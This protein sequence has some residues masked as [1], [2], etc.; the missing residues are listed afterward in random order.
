MNNMKQKPVVQNQNGSV[1]SKGKT[2][3]EAIANGLAALNLTAEQVDIDII[4]HGSR[5]ILGLGAEEAVV[6]LTPKETAPVAEPVPAADPVPP[7]EADTGFDAA[8]VGRAK[9]IL[10]ALLENMSLEGTV[11]SRLGTDLVDADDQPPLVLDIEGSDLGLLIGRRGETLQ[12][13]QFVTRQILNKEMG[14]W[15]PVVVD[16][17]SYLARRRKTLQQLADRM[18]E[19][20]VSSGRRVALEPM[21]AH[22]RRI[23]HMHLRNHDSVYTESTGEGERRKVVILPK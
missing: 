19:R 5:G 1:E 17:E 4:N 2:V 16:V 9:E 21:S 15:V 14:R 3:D 12:A 22:E 6:R 8:L 20:V 11:T 23:I 13:L 10:Q 7:A 18:A